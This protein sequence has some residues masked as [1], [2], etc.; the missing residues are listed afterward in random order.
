MPPG[1]TGGCSEKIMSLPS[2]S[3]EFEPANRNS[4]RADND[5]A[6]SS[7]RSRLLVGES[8]I[9]PDKS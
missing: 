5:S 4:V 3:G 6:A 2:I 7:D 8:E 9:T 1:K